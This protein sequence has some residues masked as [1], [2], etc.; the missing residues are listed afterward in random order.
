MLDNT[1]PMVYANFSIEQSLWSQGFQLICGIDEV[2]RG[3]FAGPLVAGAVVFSSNTPVIGGIAD[4]KQLS[5]KKRRQLDLEIREK[6]VGLGIGEVPV[7]VIDRRGI[8]QATQYAFYLAVQN[9]KLACDFFLID[10][11]PLKFV[12]ASKQK[13]VVSGDKISASIA[14]A[15]II[16]KV[17]RDS[18]MEKLHL[19][20][21]EYGFDK[22]KGYGTSFHREMIKKFGLS[23]LHRKSFDLAKFL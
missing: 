2:G 3:C 21:P 23:K 11:F 12:S 18:L 15:S 17:Y 1:Y 19:D 20:F 4:S 10:A 14:A 8:V 16:A 5:P 9:L 6:A 7:E 13:A 22:H